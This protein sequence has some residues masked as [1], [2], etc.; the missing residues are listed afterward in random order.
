MQILN[1]AKC[2]QGHWQSVTYNFWDFSAF[3]PNLTCTYRSQVVGSAFNNVSIVGY[4]FLHKEPFGGL[5]PTV[6]PLPH[7]SPPC[8]YKHLVTFLR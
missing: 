5:Q 4:Q 6:L 2:T 1:L 3:L 7:L 8:E